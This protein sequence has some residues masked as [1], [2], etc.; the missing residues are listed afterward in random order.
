MK[1]ATLPIVVTLLGIFT[2]VKLVLRKA[3]DP[4][5]VTLLGIF[6]DVKL[7]FS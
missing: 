3:L 6:T 7:V 4:I 2:D 1:K 5:V